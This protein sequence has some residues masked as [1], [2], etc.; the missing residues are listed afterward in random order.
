MSTS[1]RPRVTGRPTPLSAPVSA[2]LSRHAFAN[3]FRPSR[4]EL[5]SPLLRVAEFIPFPR[6]RDSAPRQ[7]ALTRDA[8]RGGLRLGVAE[9]Q[10]VGQMLQVIV[11]DA[12]GR[13][14]QSSIA[15]VVW[16]RLCRTQAPAAFEIGLEILARRSRTNAWQ[17]IRTSPNIQPG[18]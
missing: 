14:G 5:R 16:C 6:S 1:L 2:P 8:S 15:R 12:S 9:P 11:H 4:R 7:V 10:A 18:G 13:P 17:R 3:S